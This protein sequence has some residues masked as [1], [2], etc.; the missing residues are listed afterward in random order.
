MTTDTIGDMCLHNALKNT[1]L[2]A[3]IASQSY[4]TSVSASPPPETSHRS[5]KQEQVSS[6][7]SLICIMKRAIHTLFHTAST[8]E[9]SMA[10]LV[11]L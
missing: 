3:V 10:D 2:V 9:A 1:K 7:I 11:M 6:T 4:L 8:N 5:E